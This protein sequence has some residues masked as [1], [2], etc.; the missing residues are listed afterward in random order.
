MLFLV[1]VITRWNKSAS[2]TRREG[3]KTGALLGIFFLFLPSF[4]FLDE[5]L[6]F[7]RKIVL[8]LSTLHPEQ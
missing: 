4:K 1:L 2:S 3:A 6:R 5:H 7:Y 8:L